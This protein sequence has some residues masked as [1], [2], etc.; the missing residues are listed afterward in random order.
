MRLE[1]IRAV[2]RGDVVYLL[3]GA[4]G[5]LAAVDMA[6][7]KQLWRTETGVARSSAPV[8]DDQQVYFTSSDG[9]LL[10]VDVRKGRISGDTPS[11]LGDSDRITASLP[12]PVLIDGR[13]CAGALDGS[14][15]GLDGN[16][17]AGW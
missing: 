5:S 8:A 1:H 9:R 3:S 4:G 7:R 6:A 11:R 15:L 17:P 10:A 13:V 16:D 2:V 14:V 12:E